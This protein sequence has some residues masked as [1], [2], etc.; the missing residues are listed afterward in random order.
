MVGKEDIDETL[1][2]EVQEECE[3]NGTV[4]K[5]LIYEETNESTGESIVK[6]FVRFDTNGSARGCIK[7]LNGRFFGGRVV[8]AEEYDE[9]RYSAK[10]YTG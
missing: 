2:S 5:V 8:V 10:D 3:K 4:E 6:I 7:A 9:D 1:E